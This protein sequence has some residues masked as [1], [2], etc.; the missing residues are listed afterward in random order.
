MNSKHIW[1]ESSGLQSLWSATGTRRRAR[2]S[3]YD[4]MDAAGVTGKPSVS[5]GLSSLRTFDSS[6]SVFTYTARRVVVAR[7]T[8]TE[9]RAFFWYS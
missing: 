8:L 6:F 1:V 3:L 7:K 9:G 4:D 5:R 2:R